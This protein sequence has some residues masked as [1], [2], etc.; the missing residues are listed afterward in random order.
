MGTG[1][2]KIV[3]SLNEENIYNI[4]SSFNDETELRFNNSFMSLKD[5]SFLYL[6]EV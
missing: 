2:T 6:S 3:N 4:N 1:E 5:L